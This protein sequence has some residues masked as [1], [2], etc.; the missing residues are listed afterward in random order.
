MSTARSLPVLAFCIAGVAL[1]AP[2]SAHAEDLPPAREILEKCDAR[3]GDPAARK[4]LRTLAMRG[5]VL[6]PDC[7]SGDLKP[8]KGPFE[9]LWLAPDRARSSVEWGS[10]KLIMGTAG[11][12]SWSHDLAMGIMIT[13]GDEQL[14]MR[15]SFDLGRRAGWKEMFASAETAGTEELADLGGRKHYK[16]TMKPA[17]GESETWWVDAETFDLGAV[18]SSLP[19]MTGGAFKIRYYYSDYRDVQGIRFPYTKLMK[20]G[21]D[22]TRFEYHYES[23]EVN[24]AVKPEQVA[25]S[26]EVL[27]ALKDPTKRIAMPSAN[28]DE[29]TIEEIA[30]QP[31]LS[32]R[33][34]IPADA[35]SKTLATLIPEILGVMTE[36]GGQ[37]AGPPYCRYHSM[38]AD[39]IDLEAG[40][41]LKKKVEGKGRVKAAELPA[42]KTATTWHIGSYD[43]VSKS[44]ARLAA[45]LE[46]KSLQTAGGHWEVYWTDPGVEPDPAKWRTRIYWPLK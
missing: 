14:P 25:P 32:I 8:V 10:M 28:I 21:A 33:V 23:I 26:T 16:L 41:P 3:L 7:T 46:K 1:A 34:T 20:M 13:E 24:A 44:Q 29:C 4:Q 36:M 5:S 2:A 40:V 17:V 39:K 31:A 43:S 6:F 18:E 38:E 22:P 9:E 42:G 37:L 27:A 45:W 12:F 19:D 15:R 30:A 11:A 35:V